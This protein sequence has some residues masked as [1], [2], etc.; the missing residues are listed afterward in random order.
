M[1]FSEEKVR[2]VIEWVEV[3]LVK[4]WERKRRLLGI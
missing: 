4:L 3:F 1:G 2:V